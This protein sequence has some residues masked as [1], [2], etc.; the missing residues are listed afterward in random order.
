MSALF[1]SWPSMPVHT[2]LGHS[3]VST[4]RC[5]A[6]SQP[7]ETAST[8][9]YALQARQQLIAVVATQRI[10]VARVSNGRCRLSIEPIQIVS[11]C[12]AIR[13]L[14]VSDAT[15]TADRIVT[16]TCTDPAILCESQSRQQTC[17]R[18][19]GKCG[20]HVGIGDGAWEWARGCR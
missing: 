10:R 13:S 1:Q 8:V 12:G 20:L 17:C 5:Q 18:Q 4:V 2:L 7:Y 9:N 15:A 6:R 11:T 16:C 19:K 3:A 14:V